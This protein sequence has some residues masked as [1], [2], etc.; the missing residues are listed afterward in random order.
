MLNNS[1]AH[2]L[3]SSE[4]KRFCINSCALKFKGKK[5]NDE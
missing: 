5:R 3:I 2:A 4:G 1:F